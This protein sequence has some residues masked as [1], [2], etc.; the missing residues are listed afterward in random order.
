M[1]FEMSGKTKNYT[2][3]IGFQFVQFANNLNAKT[4]ITLSGFAS[5]IQ[6]IL[7]YRLYT[8]I[9]EKLIGFGITSQIGKEGLPP[10][11]KSK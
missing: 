3:K 8:K 11:F 2:S 10:P 6:A 1:S 5:Q 4:G 7:R 9:D